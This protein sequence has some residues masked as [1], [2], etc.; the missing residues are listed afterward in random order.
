MS[1][2]KALRG[3]ETETREL[4]GGT[5]ENNVCFPDEGSLICPPGRSMSFHKKETEKIELVARPGGGS[6]VSPSTK[7]TS[8]RLSKTKDS[9]SSLRPSDVTDSKKLKTEKIWLRSS[10]ETF[11]LQRWSKFS[12][13]H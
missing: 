2:Q 1:A 6:G 13:L 9:S 5:E 3:S 7:S 4:L 10:R 8:S 12:N 11:V